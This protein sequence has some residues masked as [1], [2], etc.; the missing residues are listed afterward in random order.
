MIYCSVFDIES[1]F[2]KSYVKC[3]ILSV[4]RHCRSQSIVPFIDDDDDQSLGRRKQVP[5]NN[6]V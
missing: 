1:I 4:A 3:V 5:T 2:K 6:T